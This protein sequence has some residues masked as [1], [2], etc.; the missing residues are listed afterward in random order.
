[1]CV[2]MLSGEHH[3]CAVWENVTQLRSLYHASVVLGWRGW[4]MDRS[5]IPFRSHQLLVQ[6]SL[7]EVYRLCLQPIFWVGKQQ[8]LGVTL[9]PGCI[10]LV[11]ERLVICWQVLCR[12][13]LTYIAQCAGKMSFI[14]NKGHSFDSSG[15]YRCTHFH[16]FFN[17]TN[18]SIWITNLYKC[19]LMELIIE[20][21]WWVRLSILLGGLWPKHSLVSHS[22]LFHLWNSS[23][24]RSPVSRTDRL[25]IYSSSKIKTV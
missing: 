24:Q 3:L 16:L 12:V 6:F 1:M 15:S 14:F 4:F 19:K 5:F 18:L 10:L 8:K 9:Q 21:I 20:M 7:S 13:A 22:H 2:F 25:R 11:A 23:E 17:C